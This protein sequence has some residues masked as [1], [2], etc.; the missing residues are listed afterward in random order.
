MRFKNILIA[1]GCVLSLNAI[2]G[3]MG[4]IM[5]EEHLWSVIGGI[6]YTDY[7]HAYHGGPYAD[8]FAQNA[9]GDGET[10][11]GRFAIARQFTVF[12]SINVG[13]ELGVQSGNLMRL[14]IPQATLDVLGGLPVQV[15]IKPMVDLLATAKFQ[16]MFNT[17]AFAVVKAGI[18]YRRM[19]VNERVTV[20][21][22]SQVGFELQ[23]GLGFNI[24]DRANLSLV[25]QGIFNNSTN[26]TINPGLGIGHISN[27]PNQNG[28]LL[29][30]SY[31]V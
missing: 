8:I 21:D 2:A 18:A 1:A 14:D 16:P 22:R 23:A 20:N 11:F 19:Q 30:L 13:A 25:Y 26:F 31:A 6:G 9:I 17:P 10:A 7:E 27:I 3:S 24:S 29:N 28:I 12:S 15:S 5:P 4:D